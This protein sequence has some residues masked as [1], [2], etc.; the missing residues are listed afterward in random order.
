MSSLAL[1]AASANVPG[2]IAAAMQGGH[3]ELFVQQFGRDMNP[4][5]GILSLKATEAAEAI[6]A[7]TVAGPGAAALVEARGHGTIVECWPSASRA[8]DLPEVLRTLPPTPIYGR[9]P[10]AKVPA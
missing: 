7:P 4:A 1:L 2:D 3:G 9:A 5:S 10:D 8:L 6:R